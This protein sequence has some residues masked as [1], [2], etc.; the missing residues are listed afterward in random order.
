MATGW[1]RSQGFDSIYRLAFD[2]IDTS[3]RCARWWSETCLADAIAYTD[4]V[5]FLPAFDHPQERARCLVSGTGLT[6]RQSAQTR[7]SM[8]TGAQAVTDSMR[9]YEWGVEGGRPEPGEIGAQPEWFYKGTA[10]FSA[11][12]IETLHVPR[13]ADDGGDEGGDR[14][15]LCDRLVEELRG[16][17]EWLWEMNFP[18]M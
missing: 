10:T 2:A 18:T 4:D 15:L 8:H 9:M 7:N 1:S 12:T 5:M 6:H 16:E 14:R 17:S 13:Y 11:G 3:S